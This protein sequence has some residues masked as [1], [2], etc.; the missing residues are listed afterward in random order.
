MDKLYKPGNPQIDV[1]HLNNFLGLME[2]LEQ[3][4][5]EQYTCLYIYLCA[6]TEGSPHTPQ[7]SVDKFTLVFAPAE[8]Q[9][10]WEAPK[11]LGIYYY[12]P[13]NKPFDSSDPNSFI[14]D[15]TELKKWHTNFVNKFLE[16]LRGTIDN[17]SDNREDTTLRDTRAIT[18][19]REDIHE[20]IEEQSIPHAKQ[21]KPISITKNV[22]A[23]FA[24]FG[25]EAGTTF[26]KRLF[27]QFHLLDAGGKPVELDETDCYDRRPKPRQQCGHCLKTDEQPGVGDNGQ[28]CPPSV[29]CPGYKPDPTNP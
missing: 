13:P 28:L 12:F 15:S 3:R 4:H 9:P 7:D 2:Y 19:C 11:E 26:P 16:N 17:S 20:L 22:D 23:M 5:G 27:V 1:F 6:Y 8:V 21:G 24:A 10:G 29:N 14:I 25:T 18:Y